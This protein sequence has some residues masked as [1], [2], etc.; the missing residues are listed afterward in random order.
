MVIK[1]PSKCCSVVSNLFQLTFLRGSWNNEF[2][3]NGHEFLEGNE[4][5]L[6]RHTN[7]LSFLIV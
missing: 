1:V 6:K 5:G 4:L 3:G 2:G 7:K